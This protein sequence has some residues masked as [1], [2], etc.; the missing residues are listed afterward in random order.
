MSVALAAAFALAAQAAVADDSGTHR[1][2]GSYV[3][4]YITVDHG[5]ETFTGGIL[6]GGTGKYEGITGSC[7]YVTEY[8]EG[9]RVVVIG[10]CS[11]SRS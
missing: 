7:S 11:W 9:A 6:R 1:S 2:I 4:E 8:L 5:A 10:D 3:R